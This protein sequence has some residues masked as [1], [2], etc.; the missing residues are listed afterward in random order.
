MGYG[1]VAFEDRFDQS[2][3]KERRRIFVLADTTIELRYVLG[4]AHRDSP[5]AAAQARHRTHPSTKQC[6]TPM[7]D[8]PPLSLSDCGECPIWSSCYPLETTS[9]ISMLAI[10]VND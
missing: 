2:S 7:L 9:G 3:C 5:I 10:Q 4:R 8:P 1:E 6:S